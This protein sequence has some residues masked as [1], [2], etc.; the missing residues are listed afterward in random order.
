ME[1][2]KKGG[3]MDGASS[4]SDGA[5]GA[6]SGMKPGAGGKPQHYGEGGK[7]DSG[8]SGEFRKSNSITD[9]VNSESEQSL[10]NNPKKIR[11]SIDTPEAQQ[12]YDDIKAKRY[13]DPAE[14]ENHPAVN[15]LEKKSAEAD[16]K[17]GDT[18]KIQTP[19]RQAQRAQ[20]KK[21]FLS[22]GAA[23]KD[24]DRFV[25]DGEIRREHK[26][27]VV[28]GLPASGKSTQIARPD[29]ERL[30][31]FIFDSDEI[32]Q[33]IPEFIESGGAAANAVHNESKDILKSA[34]S[35]FLSGG[36]RNGENLIVPVI[37][38]DVSD[39]RGKWITP[40]EE[41]GYDVE[42]KYQDADLKESLNR[43]IARALDSG[44][45]IKKDVVFNYGDKLR[46]VFEEI[47]KMKGKGGKPYVRA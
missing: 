35:Q 2:F 24:G 25:F 18:S 41:A 34:K 28:I 1:Q 32:K 5:E 6:S 8:N 44:R 19:E 3:L 11:L 36:K 33:L 27:V 15:A 29:S 9:A 21:E 17:Y 22:A 40:F 16:K 13:H 45:I 38:D 46:A 20:W 42:V 39:L 47:K 7:Y 26:M 14:L 37:G 30:G 10:T 4:E 12:L 23:R 43:V 31:A